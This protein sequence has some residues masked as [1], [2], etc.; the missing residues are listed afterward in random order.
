LG[1]RGG[2]TPR[3]FQRL[4]RAPSESALTF[5]EIQLATAVS[6]PIEKIWEVMRSSVPAWIK[7]VIR[8]AGALPARA[9]VLTHQPW[10]LTA[11]LISSILVATSV[12]IPALRRRRRSAASLNPAFDNASRQDLIPEP[13]EDGVIARVFAL[14]PVK[15]KEDKEFLQ[16]SVRRTALGPARSFVSRIE[17]MVGTRSVQHVIGWGLAGYF[18]VLPLWRSRNLLPSL[19]H[20]LENVNMVGPLLWENGINW[21]VIKV[22]TYLSSLVFLAAFQRSG[23]NVAVNPTAFT[24]LVLWVLD[25]TLFIPIASLVRLFRHQEIS[26]ENAKD[27]DVERW[28]ILADLAR[29]GRFFTR[30]LLERVGSDPE[31]ARTVLATFEDYNKALPDKHTLGSG[32][33]EII[34]LVETREQLEAQGLAPEALTQD[35][36]DAGRARFTLRHSLSRNSLA[37][38]ALLSLVWSGLV[39]DALPSSHTTMGYNA[40][41]AVDALVKS[42]IY[43]NVSKNHRRSRDRQKIRDRTRLAA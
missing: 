2:L 1:V 15:L 4:F 14:L 8:T 7:G 32:P 22:V 3:E 13:D 27:I 40:L 35:A 37:I 23:E 39:L 18:L 9:A 11:F 21:D 38:R 25:W 26:Q 16:A 29:M 6:S 31:L 43:Y 41:E 20:G 36:L 5:G 12:V 33:I 28:G 17:K 10:S 42:A 19:L 34:S 24:K 30:R